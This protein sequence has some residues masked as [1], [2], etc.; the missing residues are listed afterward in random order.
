M[1]EERAALGFMKVIAGIVLA[2]VLI[3]VALGLV[4]VGNAPDVKI[5]PG[6]P[7]IGKRT[8]VRVDVSEPSKGLTHVRVEFVQ[9][10]RVEVLAD[11]AYPPSSWVPFIK[12]AV[13]RD[14]FNLDI[15]RDTIANLKNADAL[16]RVTADR[17]GWLR[18][19]QPVMQELVVPVRLTPPALQLT[20]SQTYAAQAGCETVVYRVGDTAVRDGVR[21]AGWWFPGVPLPGGGKQDRFA[22]FAVPYDMSND[23]VRLTAA[24]VAG[25]ETERGFI[26]KFFAR[27]ARADTVQLTD[28]FMNKVV[29]EIMSQTPDVSDH[30]NLLAN[31]LA[32]NG[33]LRD[34]QNEML[35]QL[36]LKSR[37]EFL[38]SKPFLMMPNAKVMANFAERR[39]YVY[40]G[41]EVDHQ[42][43][44]G[45]DMAV[46]Q[47]APVPAS[48][49]GIVV[50]AKFFGIYGNAVII[51]HGYG[52]MS[53]YGHMS[54]L[55]VSEGQKV[56][57]GEILGETG[58][59]GLAAGDH[60]H[61]AILLQGLPVNPAEWWD[62][63][64][65]QDRIAKKLG[66]AFR[67]EP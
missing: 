55:K 36:A 31:Y 18:H 2:V 38:W 54:S 13:A 42:T 33:E 17:R 39:A 23:T 43:H 44:L 41:K 34:K 45:I 52:L 7:A 59:T 37:P 46:T 27:P 19:P 28:A 11:K 8:P 22:L 26:D 1:G 47:H 24:D 66:S 21:A 64:W 61:F 14:T 3:V 58:D 20:S 56:E 12:P 25:N 65:I 35:K 51:D 67:Y 15:G 30:G 48:N 9:G 40:Q 53:L 16:I 29:P 49:S 50:L 57:R 6:L 62:G 4:W 32:I 5:Q 10:T 63:H 60:L